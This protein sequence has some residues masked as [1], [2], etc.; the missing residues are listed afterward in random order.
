MSENDIASST[1]GHA[2]ALRAL[3]APGKRLDGLC[4]HSIDVFDVDVL[5]NTKTGLRKLVAG[6]PKTNCMEACHS[7]CT[8]PLAVSIGVRS[9]VV[10][11]QEQAT[12][13][14]EVTSY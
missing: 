2:G 13:G 10:G 1:R 8:P 5:D 7:R 9:E 11:Y 12:A 14:L 4:W 3:R 6:K